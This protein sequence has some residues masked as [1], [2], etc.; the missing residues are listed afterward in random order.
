MSNCQFIV[1]IY[2][3][4]DFHSSCFL[5]IFC[6]VVCMFLKILISLRPKQWIKNIFVLPALVFS[7]N[8]LNSSLLIVSIYAFFCFCALSGAVYILNDIADRNKDTLHPLKRRR[9]IA[10]GELSV[11]AASCVSVLLSGIAVATAF[12]LESSF[13]WIALMYLVQNIAYSIWL[14]NIVLLDVITIATGFLLRAVGGWM[15]LQ[16]PIS[17]WF[18]L[19]IFTLALFLACI[20]RRQ[21]LVLLK[22]DAVGHR[23]ILAVYSLPFLDQIIS[24]LTA[25]TLVC[26]SLYAMGVGD[27]EKL[28][29]KNMEWTIPFVL[30]GLL[31]YLFVVYEKGRGD[32]PTSVVLGD[33]PLKLT[34]ILWL[35]T[36][37]VSIYAVR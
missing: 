4:F 37:V 22:S 18:V 5:I 14:K 23:H 7:D 16:V 17:S 28:I 20:K 21:E 6:P 8:L 32:N 27:S 35:L 15:A 29:S 25:S 19:C 10:T 11:F 31:R 1:S 26:Y 2:A 13:G 30:Y 12:N 33:K 34:V 24:I 36:A 3:V 9:P